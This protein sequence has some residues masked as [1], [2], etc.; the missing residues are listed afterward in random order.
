M[1]PAASESS[2]AQEP[3]RED[4]GLYQIRL[5]ACLDVSGIVSEVDRR[6]TLIALLGAETF[7][8]LHSLVQPQN[9]TDVSFADL[10]KKLDE[11]FSPK[12]FKE[13]ERAKLFSAH[14]E[15]HETPTAFLARLRSIIAFCGYEQETDPRACSLLTAFIVGLRDQRIRARLVQEVDLDVNKALRISES[16]LKAEQE[17]RQLDRK[18]LASSALGNVAKVKTSV[19]QQVERCFRCGNTNHSEATCRF[20]KERCRACNQLGHIARMCTKKRQKPSRTVHP[21]RSVKS[22]TSVLAVGDKEEVFTCIIDGV[23]TQLQVDTGSYYTILGRNAWLNLGKPKL[24]PAHQ[25]L[26]VL[27]HYSIPLEGQRSVEVTVAGQTHQLQALFAEFDGMS[28]LGREWIR[29]LKLDLNAMFVG[30]IRDPQPDLSDILRQYDEL[31]EE[32]LG[33]CSKVKVHLQFQSEARPKFCKARPIPFALRDAVDKDLQRQ[34]SNGVLTPVEVSQWATPIV[35]VPKPNGAVRVCGDFSVTINPQLDVAQYPL[36]RP[37]ELFAKLNGGKHFSKL[38]LSEAYLQLDLDEDAKKVLVVNTHKGLFRFNRM[39]FGISSAPAIFQRTMEQ[40]TAGLEGVACYLDD[41][42]VTG[43]TE[44]E[45]LDHL[46]EVLRRLREYGFRLKKQKCEFLKT[47]VEY[48]GQIVSAEGFRP[49]P[50]KVSALLDMPEPTN[51]GELRA[52]LGLVQYYVRYVKSLSDLCAP[53]NQLL[54]NNVPWEWSSGSAQAFKEIKCRL[55]SIDSLTHFDP[56]Q[57]LYMADDAS[58]IGV[59]A[60]IYHKVNGKDKPIAHASKTLTSAQKNYAQIEKEALA[61]IFGV[62]KFH[63]YLWGR[64]FILYTDYKPLTAIFGSKRGI[65]VTAPNRMQRWALTLLGHSFDIQYKPTAQ[66]GNADGLSRLPAGP[67]PDFD[68][69]ISDDDFLLGSTGSPNVSSVLSV[70]IDKIPLKAS[71]IAK[72]TASGRI[73]SK[74]Y[75]YIMEGWPSRERDPELQPYYL[76]NT[77]LS[78]E[79]GC[80]VWGMRVV[81]PSQHRNT[82]LCLLHDG[83]IG[84]TKM[85]MLA[86]SYVWWPGMDN[87]IE[88]TCQSCGACAA[89]SDQQLPVP[90]HQWEV[91]K[92]QWYRLHADFAEFDGKTYLVVIDAY[93]KWPEVKLMRSTKASATIEALE[94]IF[95]AQGLPFQL[96]SDNRPQF[97][98]A[99]LKDFLDRLGIKH[100]LTP[101]YHPKS[102]GQAENLVRTLK[103]FLRRQKEGRDGEMEI[104]HFVLKYRITPHATTGHPACEMLNRRHYR[105]ELD[106]LR[107]NHQNASSPARD[108]Q[109]RNYD[110]RTRLRKFAASDEVWVK[111]KSRKNHWLRGTIVRSSSGP[112]YQVMTEDLKQHKMHADDIKPRLP[113]LPDID[114][115]HEV[116]SATTGGNAES[117]LAADEDIQSV[118]QARR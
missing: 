111:D 31:F 70:G 110:S 48:L 1:P 27:T 14:Q 17:S 55:T 73:L 39:P 21:R 82:V 67:D 81:V 41:I 52:F 26:R 38:D 11:H 59:G 100:I 42:I 45:H 50:K 29:V 112:T 28:L 113:E 63:Q 54:R 43:R 10:L 68:A 79:K 105:T 97:I 91:P 57:T 62:K 18:L 51:V 19:D 47:E 89:S 46:E 83:H 87:D 49:S 20:S 96:V 35:V 118:P 92:E 25:K 104:K 61:I 106:L 80:I 93:S 76:R 95:A 75:R 90:L 13:F 5:Q 74:V 99:A 116:E 103:A 115:S 71:A 77:E 88:L 23:P 109:K 37:E 8:V 107:P 16:C 3:E 78:T 6:N 56:S 34:V 7:K 114:W 30:R 33:R 58:S 108:R 36:P 65:P 64:K 102:N 117:T 60:V 86:R 85:K 9:I 22:I 44:A 98:S 84:Q 66:F 12:R 101:P 2:S 32:G 69:A 72:A 94:D 53:L 40:V 4:W 15:E 24:A